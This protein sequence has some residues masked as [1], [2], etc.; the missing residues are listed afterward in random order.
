[1]SSGLTSYARRL[2]LSEK[3]LIAA[4][5][6]PVLVWSFV[7]AKAEDEDSAW[8]GT[9][10]GGPL[11][12]PRAEEPVVFEL[13]KQPNRNPL[14]MGITVGRVETNDV[15]ITDESVSRFHAYF[16][17]KSGQWSLVDADSKN[18]TWA[19]PLKL[20]PN[21]PVAMLDG[22]RLR[23]GSVEVDFYL[24]RSFMRFLRAQMAR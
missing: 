22:S 9:A 20:S 7:G 19:G 11:K 4:I 15:S 3:E 10:A 23:F 8:T 17:E 16:L 24:P 2:H 14:A 18:G 5:D 12:R 13:R 6:C 21:V 1:M